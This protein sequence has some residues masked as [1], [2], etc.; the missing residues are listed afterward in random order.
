[1]KILFRILFP[2]LFMGMVPFG[3]ERET[4]EDCY[5]QHPFFV[6]TDFEVLNYDF[7][8][9]VNDSINYLSRS[10]SFITLRIIEKRDKYEYQLC[11]S[12]PF[13]QHAIALSPVAP[14]IHKD[15]LIATIKIYTKQPLYFKVPKD[16]FDAN[17]DISKYFKY[18]LSY[19]HPRVK[20]FFNHNPYIKTLDQLEPD[21][22]EDMNYWT[23][24]IN[25]QPKHAPRT[26]PTQAETDFYFDILV[27]LKDGSEIWIKDHLVKYKT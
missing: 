17:E 5:T 14:I 15:Y 18:A 20:A 4:R 6:P 7:V 21:D 25:L 2:L 16:T 13:Q 10:S 8:R 1:M 26:D 23:D 11:S 3:C 19:G 27:E 12:F 9:R 24:Y 22:L